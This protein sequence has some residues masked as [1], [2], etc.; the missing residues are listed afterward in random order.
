MCF[1][2]GANGGNGK[3]VSE[4]PEALYAAAM[5]QAGK[6]EFTKTMDRYYATLT[7]DGKSLNLPAPSESLLGVNSKVQ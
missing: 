7:A 5:L 1:Q 2:A 3:Q 6:P 4:T